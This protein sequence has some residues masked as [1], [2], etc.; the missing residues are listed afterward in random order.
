MPNCADIG[1]LVRIAWSGNAVGIAESAGLN[2]VD[3]R[4]LGD[5]W[6]CRAAARHQAGL[7]RFARPGRLGRVHL[8]VQRLKRVV[9]LREFGLDLA[10]LRLGRLN[11][12]GAKNF[13][14]FG[15][16]GS[17]SPPE[18]AEAAPSPLWEEPEASVSAAREYRA[19]ALQ[20]PSPC[21]WLSESSAGE[22]A[23]EGDHKRHQADLNDQAG[24]ERTHARLGFRQKCKARA[25]RLGSHHVF[26]CLGILDRTMGMPGGAEDSPA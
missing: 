6:N 5:R 21:T 25:H 22:T 16:G 19:A 1:S 26:P 11:L 12:G 2:L 24:P 8:Q 14:I 9:D 18:E 13:A 4:W 20:G 10:R 15:L 17:P 23:G 7:H 3:R